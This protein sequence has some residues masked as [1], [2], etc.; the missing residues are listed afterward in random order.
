MYLGERTRGRDNN[1]NLIRALAAAAVLV[2]HAYPLTLGPG[3]PEPLL[4]WIGHNLGT[5]SVYAFFAISGFLIAA[6][7]AR[8]NDAPAFLRARGLRLF[9]GLFVS[10]VLVG[11]AMGA[12]VTSLPLGTYLGSAGLWRFV[13]QNLLLVSPAYTLPGVFDT[14][15]YPTIEG[16]IWTLIYEVLC[17]GGVLIAGLLGAFRQRQRLIWALLG[18]FGLWTLYAGLGLDLQ[19]KITA[20]HDLSLPFAIG[21]A[22][23]AVQDRLPLSIWIAAGLGLSAGLSKA[24]PLADPVLMLALCYAVFWC[25]YGPRSAWLLAYNR[26]GDYSYGI[27]IYAFPLQGLVVWLWG[28]MT[29]FWNIALSLPL[30]LICAILSWHLI[31]APALALR[32]RRRA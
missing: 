27:Y 8:L 24:T 13:P 10:L 4:G 16:S 9:P 6:S 15:P 22:F 2:S 7:Y 12:L 28:P 19:P 5:L 31:E 17:Y 30:T 20:L 1:F 26:L 29:P 14:N 23:F 3:T 32:Q 25:A 18:Y 11:F 21:V